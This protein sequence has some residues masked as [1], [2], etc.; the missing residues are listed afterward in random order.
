MYTI[1]FRK[2]KI[3]L[4]LTTDDKYA[5]EKQLNLIINQASNYTS[6]NKCIAKESVNNIVEDISNIIEETNTIIENIPT[7][8]NLT[9]EEIK[10]E[11][12]NIIQE[13]VQPAVFKHITDDEK[14]SVIQNNEEIIPQTID[15]SSSKPITINSIQNPEPDPKPDFDKI[16]NSEIE[17]NT[18]NIPIN[19]DE[20]FINYVEGKSALDKL[21][22]LVVTAQYLAQYE[23]MNTFNLKHINVKLM[24]NF[25]LIVDH[26]VLQSAIAREFITRIHDSGDDVS[27]EYM[28]TEKGLRSY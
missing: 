8:T 16:L 10:Q 22:F 7:N 1:I 19:K 26:S 27:S 12:Q 28:L 5:V 4:E 15:I 25:T 13:N 21:D 14:N 2:G 23:N 24:Q 9:Q 3:E 20:R 18:D 17:Q 6:I 11:N